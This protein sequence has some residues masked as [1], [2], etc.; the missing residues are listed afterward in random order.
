MAKSYFME[1]ELEFIDD[2]LGSWPS[3]PYLA[4]DYIA[5]KAPD[6]ETREEEVANLGAEAVLDK[7]KTIFPRDR[8]GKPC[9]MAHQIRGFFKEACRAL[10]GNKEY[11][12]ASVRAYKKE[13]NSRIFVSPKYIALE[14]VEN[15][16][17]FQRPL[18]A[19]TPLG[20]RIALANSETV[21]EGVVIHFTV[22]A[23]S[24]KD[25]DY[26]REWLDYGRLQGLGQWRNAGYG[27]FIWKEVKTYAE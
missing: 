3:N 4:E 13:I 6:A 7:Q 1:V 20:E 14:Q 17:D 2:I 18:R 25:L 16:Y 23:I 8:D 10:S 11:L 12:S 9:V 26:V 22:Q 27:R 21:S 15:V 5:S 24:P 19:S